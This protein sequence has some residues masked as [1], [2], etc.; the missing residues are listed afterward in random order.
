MSA[1]TN[2]PTRYIEHHLTNLTYP[3]TEQGS[4]WTLNIDTM[5]FSIILG[6]L[7]LWFFWRTARRAT[8]AVPGGVQNFIEV[9]VEFVDGQVKDTFHGKNPLIAPMALSIFVW[10][11]L[12]NCM[13]LVPVDLLP[14]LGHMVGVNYLRVVPTADLNTTLGLS[15]S[16][17]VLIL[18]FSVT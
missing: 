13:D 12:M 1:G 6:G 5:F 3:L 2:D 17:F 14:T 10:I 18:F 9:L 8:A 4:F 15:L 11:F 7:F 16:V